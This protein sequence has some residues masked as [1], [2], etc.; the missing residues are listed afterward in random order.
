MLVTT[1]ALAGLI[2][3]GCGAAKPDAFLKEGATGGKAEVEM[4][5]LAVQRGGSQA[6]KDFGQ[7]MVT[8]HSKVNA[9][10]AQLAAGK[11]VALPDALSSEQQSMLDKLSKL[12]GAEFDKQYVDAMVDDHEKDVKAFQNEAN[13]GADPDVK[14]FAARTLPTLQHHLEMIKGIKSKM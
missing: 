10:L 11:S 3:T 6:V 14:A 4:G 2:T 12:S 13:S 5:R 7:Q 8:D 9:E 1:L